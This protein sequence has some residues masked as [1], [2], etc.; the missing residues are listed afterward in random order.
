MSAKKEPSE[1]RVFASL[2]RMS[3]KEKHAVVRRALKRG[4]SVST[5]LLTLVRA[6]IA[7][8]AA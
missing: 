1:R 7:R 6:D 5:Y 8:K 4:V 3:Q 2:V